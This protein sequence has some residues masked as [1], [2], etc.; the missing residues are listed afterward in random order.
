MKI[1]FITQFFILTVVLMQ[2]TVGSAFETDQY[3]LPPK[4]LADIGIE[5][6][7]YVETTVKAAVL[8]VNTEILV[9][10]NCLKTQAKDCE[11]VEKTNKR[12][13]YLRSDDAV[14]REVYK[15]LGGGIVPY[16][17]SGSWLESH[18]FNAQPARFKPGFRESLFVFYPT[19][20]FELA[21]TIKMFDAQ[22]GTDKIAHFF[23]EGYD[24]FEKYKKELNKGSTIN[25]ATRKAIESGQK[26]ERG[27]YGTIISGV[28][29]NGD[30]AANYVGLKFYQGFTEELK[31]DGKMR[32]SLLKLDD[33]IWTFNES[34]EMK[35]MLLKP[36]ISDHLNE[37]LNP[38]GFTRFFGLNSQ[39]R[40]V[41]TRNCL[42]WRG[43]NP[44]LKQADF[45]NLTNSLKRWNNE[46]YGFTEKKNFV[47]IGNTCFEETQKL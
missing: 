38:S 1:R 29:S 5:V 30:L 35:S 14:A 10:E 23:Q 32:P 17:N 42:N 39:V 43:Q 22:F 16:T 27:I 15:V 36:F 12:L 47:T 46:D 20:Y 19:S 31:I 6:N 44:S 24:Y 25:Q 9:R 40:K 8:K 7:D 33:G 45:E 41:L 3:N 34:F 28:Y 26:S 2:A 37:A 11:S 4:P 13:A 21:S 18:Q